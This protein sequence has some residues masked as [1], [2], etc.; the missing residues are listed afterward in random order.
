MKKNKSTTM[1]ILPKRFDLNLIPIFVEIFTENSV[2]LA[3]AKMGI[4][5]SSTSQAL[6]RLREY[7]NDTLFI[8]NGQH[9]Q[10]TPKAI[11]LYESLQDNCDHLVSQLNREM[12]ENTHQKVIVYC[13]PY[14]SV[15]LMPKLSDCIWSHYP[16]CEIAHKS[17]LSDSQ[18]HENLLRFRNI[19]FILDF[20]PNL[21]RSMRSIPI[22]KEEFCFV[23]SKNNPIINKELNEENAKNEKF[24][25]FEMQK[26]EFNETTFDIKNIVGDRNAVLKS[27]SFFTML[28][29]IE[30]RDYIGVVPTWMYEKFKLSFNLERL[31]TSTLIAPQ[32]IYLIYNKS[33]ENDFFWEEIIK[34]L[35]KLQ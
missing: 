7:F 22:L 1:E 33:S 32:N 15:R 8:R 24:V 25:V 20:K 21:S 5:S 17:H 19:D 27:N 28:S 6:N 18:Y 13:S 16:K 31:N 29:M 12:H 2:S 11:K 10:P 3:A 26:K 34:K 35:T 9:I 14:L 30:S 4:S 23:S